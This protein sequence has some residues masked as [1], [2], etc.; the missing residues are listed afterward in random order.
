MQAFLPLPHV[1]A[2]LASISS[3]ASQFFLGGHISH[4]EY[5]PVDNRILDEQHGAAA[6]P[7]GSEFSTVTCHMMDS[8]LSHILCILTLSILGYDDG[9]NDA[10]NNDID[11]ADAMDTKAF[12][13][14]SQG[15]DV[16]NI[17]LPTQGLAIKSPLAEIL[18]NPDQLP[19]QTEVAGM[20]KTLTMVID[21]FPFGSPGTPISGLDDISTVN[22]P[23]LVADGDLTWAQFHSRCDWEVAYWAKLH[24]P[25]SMA[26]TD[27]LAIPEVSGHLLLLILVLTCRERLSRSLSFC[28][29]QQKN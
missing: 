16:L 5:D 18:D 20:E 2:A 6:Q 26:V 27:L 17:D 3:H 21:K 29:K 4:D 10:Y 19:I 12:K 7:S 8:N 13:M 9:I 23:N 22:G 1:T 24:G 15:I 11:P 28:I 25:T 14:L